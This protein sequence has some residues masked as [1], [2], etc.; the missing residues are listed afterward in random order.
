MKKSDNI[1]KKL[2]RKIGPGFITGASDDDPSG[3]AIYSI[4]GAKT[5]YNFLWTPIFTLPFMIAIQELCGK[6]AIVTKKGLT[7]IIKTIVSPYISYSIAFLMFFANTFNIAADLRAI[8]DSLNLITKISTEFWLITTALFVV[9]V[10]TLL[11]YKKFA[12][13]MKFFTF[14]LL[15]YIV[16][17]LMIKI[18]WIN[19]LHSTFIPKI[20]FSKET[21]LMLAA[22][23]GTT[24]SPYLFFWQSEEEIEE[25]EERPNLKP[26]KIRREIKKMRA[27]TF[28]GMFFS[29]LVMFFII[30]ASANILF[31]ANTTSMS[32]ENL[33]IKDIA[34]AL[35]PVAGNFSYIL[36]ALAIIGTGLLAIP[37]LSASAAYILSEVFEFPACINK[38]IKDAKLFYIAISCSV[39]FGLLLSFLPIKTID[40]LFYTGVM[41]ALISPLLIFLILMISNNKKIMGDYKNSLFENILG[42]IILLIMTTVSLLSFL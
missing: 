26:K 33:E 9:C 30:L 23:L 7:G 34:N 42:V 16:S 19:V 18:N 15:A 24:I 2:W 35:K 39:F 37:V 1:L 41:F 40:L 28:G 25:I 38:K 13:I 10:I 22:I 32:F 29:N 12:N 11:S 4:T 21:F 8:A 36:F 20:N 14:S 17:A 3:I 27:D 6:I 31:N 5:N